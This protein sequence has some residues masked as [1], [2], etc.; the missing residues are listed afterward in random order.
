V[1]L[2]AGLA[3]VV[4]VAGVMAVRVGVAVGPARSA[5][6]VARGPEVGAPRVA[7]GPV[8]ERPAGAA[9]RLEVRGGGA[10]IVTVSNDPGVLTRYEAP[11][12]EGRIVVVDDAGALT[13]LERAG[14]PGLIEVD[15][16]VI[17][18]R[19]LPRAEE[20]RRDPGLTP[21]SGVEGGL[22]RGRA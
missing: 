9:E 16:R 12:S 4:L 3:A 11:R 21:R 8:V 2:R 15:G 20:G 6:R 10:R 14:S 5:E 13:L 7:R 22:D 18:S 17:L 1:A 19:D